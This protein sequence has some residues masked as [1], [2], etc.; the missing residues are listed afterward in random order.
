M[1]N[2]FPQPLTSFVG[3]EWELRELA[4]LL[5]RHRLVTLVGAGGC[6][7][8][9]L[10][11]ELARRQPGFPADRIWFADL[12]AVENPAYVEAVVARAV[13]VVPSGEDLRAPMARRL[14]E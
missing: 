7:K 11:I 14:S 9:R 2:R 13:G 12:A 6:G 3:R 10:A 1:V 4:D 8:T 5:P